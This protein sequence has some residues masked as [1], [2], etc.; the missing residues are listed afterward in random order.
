MS[1][2]GQGPTD[3]I[4]SMEHEKKEE[5]RSISGL[6]VHIEGRTRHSNYNT[7]HVPTTDNIGPC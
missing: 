3:D 1:G 5:N 4:I 7:R 6:L 2:I